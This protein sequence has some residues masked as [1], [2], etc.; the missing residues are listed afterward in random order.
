MSDEK[1]QQLIAEGKLRADGERILRCPVC[2]QEIPPELEHLVLAGSAVGE[3]EAVQVLP[4]S[5]N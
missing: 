4:S 1:R 5:D 3:A 2:T